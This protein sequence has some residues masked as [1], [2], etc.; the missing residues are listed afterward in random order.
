MLEINHFQPLGLSKL[1]SV[2]GYL[3]GK[4]VHIPYPIH[5]A[6]RWCFSWIGWRLNDGFRGWLLNWRGK[7]MEMLGFWGGWN[8]RYVYE[9]KGKQIKKMSRCCTRHMVSFYESEV[10][11]SL[12]TVPEKS[13]HEHRFIK[14]SHLS[15]VWLWWWHLF[16]YV[17][18]AE[19]VNQLQGVV[20]HCCLCLVCCV[21]LSHWTIS[22]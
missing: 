8:T 1:G 12:L 14:F 22:R 20:H 11:P 4:F 21:I 7:W 10:C 15:H 18:L 16:C 2:I 17:S 9:I 6:V 5:L 19:V 13:Q 3:W